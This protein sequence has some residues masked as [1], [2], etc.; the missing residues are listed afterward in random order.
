M[1]LDLGDR[2]LIIDIFNR[3]SKLWYELD[4]N[5]RGKA[6]KNI[7]NKIKKKN[8]EKISDNMKKKIFEILNT[9]KLSDEKKLRK[10]IMLYKTPGFGKK[11]AVDFALGKP[12]IKTKMM[13]IGLKYGDK[14]NKHLTIK[15][16]NSIVLKIQNAIKKYI[17]KIVV[18]GSYRRKIK[19]MSDI[20]LLVIGNEK[21]IIETIEKE[22]W[23][24]DWLGR[25][26]KKITFL[27]KDKIG[28]IH[29][30]IIFAKKEYYGSALL[31]FTGSKIFNIRMRK[32][33][34][35]KGWKLNEYGL[36]INDKKITKEKEIIDKLEFNKKYYKPKNR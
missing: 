1:K 27:L 8:Y 14:I 35:D 24:V 34:K 3:M 20:D 28:Y 4:D 29:V 16:V 11:K 25:G 5:F 9:K 15:D 26:E 31:Y 36:F 22:E 12:I 23:F 32:K 7:A 10:A 33:A 18:V 2:I 19:T 17:D 13:E 6:Y 21:K 30:D